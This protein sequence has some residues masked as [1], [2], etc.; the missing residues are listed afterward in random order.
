VE[1]C[2]EFRTLITREGGFVASDVWEAHAELCHVI[3]KADA[4]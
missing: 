1:H 2:N 4:L 3:N